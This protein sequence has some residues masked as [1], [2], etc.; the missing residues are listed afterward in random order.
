MTLKKVQ[1]K[2]TINYWK[3]Q[4]KKKMFQIGENILC[5]EKK[6]KMI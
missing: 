3:I 1:L 4:M 6:L 2:S 5:F